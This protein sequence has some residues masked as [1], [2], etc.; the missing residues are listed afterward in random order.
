MRSG[1]ML[2][3]PTPNPEQT[4]F[5]VCERSGFH[6]RRPP[7]DWLC[8]YSGVCAKWCSTITLSGQGISIQGNGTKGRSDDYGLDACSS[9]ST[10][11]LVHPLTHKQISTDN[12]GG[13]NCGVE[14]AAPLTRLTMMA[15]FFRFCFKENPTN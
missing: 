15:L 2:D 5:S 12:G 13:R 6:L 11:H 9:S 14:T 7:S 1:Q 10:I 3:P 4:F 8:G